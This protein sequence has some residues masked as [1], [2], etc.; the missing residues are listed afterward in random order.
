MTDGEQTRAGIELGE[1]Y[2]TPMLDI[3]ARY[4]ELARTR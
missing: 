3:E 4:E 1:D 2:P